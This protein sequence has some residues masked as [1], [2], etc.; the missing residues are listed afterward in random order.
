MF[1]VKYKYSPEKPEIVYAV[2]KT[3]SGRIEFLVYMYREW[4]WCDANK[5]EPWEEES[6]GGEVRNSTQQG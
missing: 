2:H 1:K 5:C 6:A 4:L 3:D